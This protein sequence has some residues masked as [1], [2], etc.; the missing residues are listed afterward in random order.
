VGKKL[1]DVN[2]LTPEFHPHDKPVMVA[3]DIEDRKSPTMSV[4]GN[5]F[6]TSSR[7]CHVAALAVSSHT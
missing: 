1:F 7:D 5:D 3:F 2:T 4:A 6:R